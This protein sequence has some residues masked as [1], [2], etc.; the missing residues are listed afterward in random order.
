MVSKIID[1]TLSMETFACR[2]ED[3]KR[4]LAEAHLQAAQSL[5]VLGSEETD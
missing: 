5:E 1:Q 4:Q 2:Y 3:V